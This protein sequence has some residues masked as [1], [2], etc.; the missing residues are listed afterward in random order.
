MIKFAFGLTIVIGVI[1]TILAHDTRAFTFLIQSIVPPE[2]A[3]EPSPMRLF[4][5]AARLKGHH[6]LAAELDTMRRELRDEEGQDPILAGLRWDQPGLLGF[7]CEG[8]PQAYSFGLILHI[9]RHSQYDF[10]RPNPVDDAQ[11][12][13]G[14]T[15]LVVGG[16]YPAEDFKGVLTR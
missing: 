7:Y 3:S 8:H 15:F 2:T 11:A 6:I 16:G 9:D 13:R 4:D 10:W 14:R 1:L 12:F 5:P